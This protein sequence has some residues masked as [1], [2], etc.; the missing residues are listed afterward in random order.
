MKIEQ[1]KITINQDVYV[2]TDGTVFADKYECQE[3]ET[4]KLEKEL[5]M[6]GADYTKCDSLNTCIYVKLITRDQISRFTTACGHYDISTD[7]VKGP[8]IYMYNGRLRGAWINLTEVVNKLNGKR[9]IFHL[10]VRRDSTEKWTPWTDC[11]SGESLDEHI[12][13]IESHGWEWRVG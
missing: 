11:T 2:A 3:Y 9:T 6:Y 1:R 13:T 7:G 4:K 8:G 10:Y 12:K 5:D